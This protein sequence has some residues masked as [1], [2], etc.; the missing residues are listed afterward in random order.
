MNVYEDHDIRSYRFAYYLIGC[1]SATLLNNTEKV[2][3]FNFSLQAICFFEKHYGKKLIVDL[4]FVV[5]F[6]YNKGY[7]IVV[8]PFEKL[9]F[10]NID[11]PKLNMVFPIYDMPELCIRIDNRSNKI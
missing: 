8:I 3:Y 1:I 5:D 9:E 6:F 10:S 7:D 4:E 2:N 11:S